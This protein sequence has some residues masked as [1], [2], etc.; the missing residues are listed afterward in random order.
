MKLAIVISQFNTDVTNGLKKGAM[1]LLKEKGVAKDQIETFEAPGAF[2][3]P[4]IAQ[5]LARTKKYDGIICLGCVIK[6]D[7]AHF[8]FISLGATLGIQMAS[9]QTETPITFGILTT[10]T[11]EQAL[12]RS[13]RDENNKGREA[14]LACLDALETLKLIRLH[15]L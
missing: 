13:D 9:M 7:T 1:A 11:E 6:G 5:T 4:L 10:Y 2:E 8:E 3:I 14:A 12:V 15:S